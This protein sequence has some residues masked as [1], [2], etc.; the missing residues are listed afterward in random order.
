MFFTKSG[1]PY[2]LHY[3]LIEDSVLMTEQ[4]AYR[5]DLVVDSVYVPNIPLEL[6]CNEINNVSPLSLA[7]GKKYL[8]PS[9]RYIHTFLEGGS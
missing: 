4:Q 5:P 7:P 1:L 3:L 8:T 6:F 9:F 2:S